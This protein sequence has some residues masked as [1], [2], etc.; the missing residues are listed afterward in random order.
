VKQNILRAHGTGGRST[1]ELIRKIFLPYLDNDHLS[2]NDA[3]EIPWTSKNLV[4]TTDTTVVDPLIFP[5]GDAGKL[6]MTGGINDLLTRGAR[7]QYASMGFV[8]SENLSFDV[9]NQILKSISVELE[10][11]K[12]KFVCADTKVISSSEKPS[13][14][15]NT[16]LL[17]SPINP[18]FHLRGIQNGDALVLT[19]NLG[20]HGLAILQARQNLPFKTVFESDCTSLF[21][22][23]E[24]E[25]QNAT[26]MSYMRDVTRG[27]LAGILHELAKQFKVGFQLNESRLPIQRAVRSGLSLL[28][29]D[30][31]EVANEG[32]M[33][34]TVPETH[35]DQL[36]MNLHSHPLGRSAVKVGQTVNTSDTPLV[37]KT[38]VGGERIINWPEA[39]NLPRIC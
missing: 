10:S 35:V 3:A 14:M 19:G 11:H 15:I 22:L 6:A 12:I 26:P 33:L 5:G 2:P 28:G 34:I 30:P 4:I 17:G 25:I 21:S 27:G 32:V 9:I 31:L 24:P 13:M 23:L 1:H 36:I 37:L 20:N 29:I 16:T 7:P 39:L 18:N 8:L 38:T